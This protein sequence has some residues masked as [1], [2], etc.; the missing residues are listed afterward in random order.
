MK[1]LLQDQGLKIN[2]IVT[3]RLKQLLTIT[4]S[5]CSVSCWQCLSKYQNL[6][7]YGQETDSYWDGSSSFIWVFFLRRILVG[8]GISITW[9]LPGC[10]FGIIWVSSVS[11]CLTYLVYG[12]ENKKVVTCVCVCWTPDTLLY[13]HTHRS[14]LFWFLSNYHTIVLISH[15]NKVILKILQVRLWQY[16]KNFQMYKLDLEKGE[17]PE[18]KLLTS[19]GS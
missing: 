17:E 5:I 18:I 13:E 1:E 6:A 11:F 12:D 9:F 14:L 10:H 19:A 3:G 2:I 4:H 16:M 8:L 15:A 7:L